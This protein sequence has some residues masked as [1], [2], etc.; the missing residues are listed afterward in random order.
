METM[1]HVFSLWSKTAFSCKLKNESNGKQGLR[2]RAAK[3]NLQKK[4]G[5]GLKEY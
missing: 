1:T 2:K 4:G 3:L 5:R